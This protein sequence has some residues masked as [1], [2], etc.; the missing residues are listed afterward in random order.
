MLTDSVEKRIE[1]NALQ[2]GIPFRPIMF[3]SI[4]KSFTPDIP[5]NLS[6]RPRFVHCASLSFSVLLCLS[7]FCSLSYCSYYFD[8]YYDELGALLRKFSF[9]ALDC[10]SVCHGDKLSTISALV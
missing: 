10:R 9:P 8:I 3:D 7:Y 6:G 1:N 4:L 5:D 2:T